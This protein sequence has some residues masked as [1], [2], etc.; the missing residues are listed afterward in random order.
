MAAD[1][2]KHLNHP[3]LQRRHGYPIG[4]LVLFC[5]SFMFCKRKRTLFRVSFGLSKSILP[6]TTFL[7]GPLLRPQN[8]LFSFLFSVLALS[9]LP[10]SHSQLL[11][12]CFCLLAASS[13][14]SRS[15]LAIPVSHDSIAPFPF[16]SLPLLPA[17]PTPIHPLQKNNVLAFFFP[18]SFV[19]VM[20]KIIFTLHSWAVGFVFLFSAGERCK[21]I[22]K[23]G[24]AHV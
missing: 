5:L 8:P 16:R 13:D 20:K 6:C 4:F 22:Y 3:S 23:I 15:D 17:P 21:R 10:L 19:L 9:A 18:V 24:R 2:E 1:E 7:N 12:P 14:P 11:R